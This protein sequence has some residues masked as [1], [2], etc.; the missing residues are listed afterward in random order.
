MVSAAT[1][2]MKPVL[3]KLT[4]LLSEEYKLQKKVKSD[5]TFLKKE[6]SSMN[7]LLEKLADTE[8]LDRQQKEWRNQVREMAYDIEDCIDDYMHR[9]H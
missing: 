4:T 2:V 3:T 7:A 8:V 9:P 5:V 6:L 1:G